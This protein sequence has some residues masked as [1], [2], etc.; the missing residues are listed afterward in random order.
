MASLRDGA[1]ATLDPAESTQRLAGCEG[2]E[3]SRASPTRRGARVESVGEWLD[4]CQ[5]DPSRG[6]AP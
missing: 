3:A 5:M 1:S 2:T 6:L 4:R